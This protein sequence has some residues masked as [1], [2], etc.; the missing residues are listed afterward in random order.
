MGQARSIAVRIAVDGDLEAIAA[1]SVGSP[2]FPP[3]PVYG[4]GRTVWFVDRLTGPD[5]AGLLAGVS[6]TAAAR[7]DARICVVASPDDQTLEAVLTI[8]GLQRTV[9]V[10]RWPT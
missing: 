7:G 8:A 6:A 3:P 9:D 2:S 10:Y 5:A 1:L 4:D